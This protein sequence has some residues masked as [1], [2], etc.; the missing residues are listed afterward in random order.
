MLKAM[1]KR[2]FY[3]LVFIGM[4]FSALALLFYYW[5]I[6]FDFFILVLSLILLTSILFFTFYQRDSARNQGKYIA[7]AIALLGTLGA[8]SLHS[9]LNK[10]EKNQLQDR[11]ALTASNHLLTLQTSASRLTLLAE[12]IQNLSYLIDIAEPDT[13]QQFASI[14]IANNPIIEQLI[15]LPVVYDQSL[16]REKLTE[17]YQTDIE[18]FAFNESGKTLLGK[19]DIYTPISLI[20]PA[21]R[22]TS[23]V[24]N[25]IGFD[26][27]SENVTK[28]KIEDLLSNRV[29][30]HLAIPEKSTF[31]KTMNLTSIAS[32]IY[33]KPS[34]NNTTAIT[35]SEIKGLLLIGYNLA[36][37]VEITIANNSS[38]IGLHLLVQD[39]TQPNFSH[40]HQSRKQ[41]NITVS[42]DSLSNSRK[43]QGQLLLADKKFAVTYWP[44]KNFIYQNNSFLA[45]WLALLMLIASWVFALYQYRWA[46]QTIK[47][48][49]IKR[50]QLA[51]INALPNAVAVQNA[52]QQFSDYNNEFKKLFYNTTEKHDEFHQ[53]E[54]EDITAL[55]QFTQQ[56]IALLAQNGEATS[57]F[58]FQ[59]KD[60]NKKVFLYL[61]KAVTLEQHKYLVASF[62][63]ITQLKKTEQALS[64]A[65]HHA[66]QIFH[67]APIA[68]LISNQQ[69][70]IT[71]INHAGEELI[72][73]TSSEIIGQSIEILV[74]KE[75][76]NQHKSM[77]EG[78]IHSQ[79]TRAMNDIDTLILVTKT[80]KK[81]PVAISLSPIST[82]ADRQVVASIRDISESKAYEIA[83]KNAKDVAESANSAKSDFLA[84][85]SHEIRTPMNTIIGFCHLV[86]ETQL[87]D[88]QKRNINRVKTAANSLLKIINDILDLSKVEAKKI[89]LERIPFNLYRDVLSHLADITSLKF[90]EQNIK[91]IFKFDETL[92]NEIIGDPLRLSQVL[93]NLVSNASKFTEQGE[94]TLEIQQSISHHN[95]LNNQ[96]VALKFIVSDTGIG[97]S[98]EQVDGLFIPFNQADSSTTRTYGGT[99]LGLSICSQ[100]VELMGGKIGV[101]SEPNVGSTFWFELT[102]D[103]SNSE[104]AAVQLNESEYS[105]NA[106]KILLVDND[107]SSFI[108][109][110]NQL[111]D[112][113]I[114]A[115]IEHNML[116]E[117]N[118]TIKNSHYELIFISC[119]PSNF[120][121][122]SLL[123]QPLD[124]HQLPPL[125]LLT[126]AVEETRQHCLK[127]TINYLDIIAKPILPAALFNSIVKVIDQQKLKHI[128]SHHEP[129]SY[130]SAGKN[131]LLAEDNLTS[132]EL[133]STLLKNVGFS[134]LIANNGQEVLT[135]LNQHHVDIVLMDIQMPLMD[136]LTAT[137]RIREIKEFSTLPII[138]MT[139]N[140]L[141]GDS[142]LSIAAGMNAHLTKPINLKELY[143]ALATFLE[144]SDQQNPVPSSDEHYNPELQPSASTLDTIVKQ[145]ITTSDASDFDS[146]QFKRAINQ[147]ASLL[148]D[149]DT[150]AIAMAMARQLL[151]TK[152]DFQTEL[153]QIF[154][155]C[156]NYNFESASHIVA[157]VMKNL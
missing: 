16:Y 5:P 75:V 157:R 25:V 3:S 140:A 57:E 139:A 12:N 21:L 143:K 141:V 17:I 108:P 74:P 90:A 19:K 54:P 105:S 122:L 130:L 77:R 55:N 18:L 151:S 65:F 129:I 14:F 142:E 72:E 39:I 27:L 79:R 81:L 106:I 66:H 47:N 8:F 71:Q 138:A 86:L 58:T 121:T 149:N 88:M 132:Q 146:E 99:G 62:H 103:L 135:I 95:P 60:N 24:N 2:W 42:P 22:N 104:Q 69:G 30:A 33:Q 125:F 89:E 85:M 117:F 150:E 113:G 111:N 52:E 49:D 91:F 32:I 53:F 145:R 70:I 155:L 31:P 46:Q 94:I 37:L 128:Q 13:F 83:L 109:L 156:D 112:F 93:N 84:N 110:K 61:R 136:G 59:D 64:H 41:K 20:Y 50:Y 36:N 127:H 144:D 87:D 97:M 100:L 107:A 147:L 23:E 56:D 4:L 101:S 115:D 7:V 67:L 131:I 68:M 9:N 152:H 15:W 116:E 73:Y 44:A 82:G 98:P 134:V 45:N 51:L 80:G 28:K 1:K 137:K 76:K 153:Q 120:E 10:K 26:L 11:F 78:F 34:V 63:D 154:E 92:T 123:M 35:R 29:V 114:R 38:P 148:Q 6:P 40:F 43:W 126:M 96:Q 118:K 133:V 102:F 119:E 124:Q 48:T